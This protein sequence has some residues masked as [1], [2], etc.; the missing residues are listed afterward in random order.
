MLHQGALMGGTPSAARLHLWHRQVPQCSLLQ[1]VVVYA[2]LTTVCVTAGQLEF[3][4]IDRPFK[5]VAQ[6]QA[7]EGIINAADCCGGK[8]T[9]ASSASIDACGTLLLI[10]LSE[11]A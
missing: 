4:D 3:W 10:G 9:T 7:H 2:S 1:C 5:P 11:F 6:L 8:V